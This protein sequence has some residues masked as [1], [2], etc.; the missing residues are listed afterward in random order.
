MLTVR[1]PRYSAETATLKEMPRTEP[2]KAD[3]S[4]TPEV[5]EKKHAI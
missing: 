3:D 1:R 2:P 5:L 4:I